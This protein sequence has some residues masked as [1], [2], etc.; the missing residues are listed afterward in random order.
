MW[1]AWPWVSAPALAARSIAGAAGATPKKEPKGG[2][3]GYRPRSCSAHGHSMDAIFI[4]HGPA[5]RRARLDSLSMLH[6]HRLLCAVLGIEPAPESAGGAAF[7]E[8]AR[9]LLHAPPIDDN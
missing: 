3:H 2:E 8:A 6:V 1:G 7:R 5:F 9:A 4:A